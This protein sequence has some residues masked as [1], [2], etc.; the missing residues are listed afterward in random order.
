MDFL[1]IIMTP[2]SWLL[3]VFCQVFDSYGIALILFTIVVK[4]IL[5]PFNL[6]GKKG[7][8]KMNLISGQLREIQKRCGND[9]ERYNQEVQKFYSENNVSPMGGCIWQLIPLLILWPLYA[10]I[11]RPFRYMMGLSDTAIASV[12][13]ALGWS[14][15]ASM[16]GAY[17][18]L[19]LAA[20][21]NS[22]NL[23]TATAAAAG[24]SLFVIN[25]SFLGMD[26]AEIPNLMFWQDGIDWNSI[27][28]FLLP[29]IS[30]VLSLLSM[31]VSQRTNRM[32]RN[33]EMDKSTA[34]TNRTMMIVSP[35]ISLW[36]GY[37]MP[38]GLCIYWIANSLLMM[39]QEVICGKI[40]RKD[41]EAA[42]REMEEQARKAK[43]EEKER[44]RIA[45]EKKAAAIASGSYKKGK[46]VQPKAKN[47]GTDVSA[48]REGM[49]TY[50]RGRAYD[51]DRYPITPYHDPDDKYKKKEPE[52]ELTPLTEEEKA[53]LA[54]N[55]VPIP[56]MPPETMED[57]AAEAIE[58]A[59]GDEAVQEEQPAP[60]EEDGQSAADEGDYEAPYAADEET[61]DKK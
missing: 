21:L 13:G 11:R 20:D 12:A 51:P 38:A 42:Q 35:L 32:N 26:L 55:G 4:L 25:F 57:D 45:A 46:K 61:Q 8:I 18:E 40:L 54:E 31:L 52:E 39:V 53:I 7:M 6:K 23:A 47:K 36:I 27:G 15:Y 59:C 43:E 29:I 17:K 24:S 33:Q 60:A 10:I 1:Q 30:A 41:Y 34:S 9:R 50:A 49:R 14:D 16:T 2:F 56:E 5:F 28:L 58:A 3:R 22:T 37:S 48:S 19:T 44:R